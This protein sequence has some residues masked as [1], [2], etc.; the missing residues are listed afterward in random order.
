MVLAL[1]ILLVAGAAFGAINA[2]ILI[3]HLTVFW[4]I[5]DGIGKLLERKRG[6]EFERYYAGM[7]AIGM[8][9][10]Y[11][12]C[13]WYLAHHVW[14]SGY[15]V[16][17]DK[18]VGSLRIALFADSHVGNTFNGKGMLAHV[19]QIQE[20]Q[21]DLV[22]IADDFVDDDTSKEDM[23][24]ACRALGTLKTTFGVY[25]VFGNHD[26]GYYGSEYRG[27]SGDDLVSELEKN[28]VRVLE[29]E[30]VL[31]DGRFC[32]IGRRDRSEGQTGE[33]FHG[34]ID[35]RAASGPVQHCFRPS[36]P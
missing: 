31:L 11:L 19:K 20:E 35:G 9:A 32:L 22:A 8:T 7:C 36:A 26:K 18:P 6:G 24:A 15:A 2:A 3:L 27:Y 10:A 5:C 17:T 21:P 29:D 13:G 4:L 28:N 23:A 1:L 34:R 16:S 12:A 25:Y 14:R 30:T 33:G